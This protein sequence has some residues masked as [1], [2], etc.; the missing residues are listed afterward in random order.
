MASLAT[1]YMIIRGIGGI[2]R[3]TS[4]KNERTWFASQMGSIIRKEEEWPVQLPET[5]SLPPF[6]PYVWHHNINGWSFKWKCWRARNIWRLPCTWFSKNR[7]KVLISF[8]ISCFFFHL[9]V[10]IFRELNAF[11]SRWPRCARVSVAN[12]SAVHFVLLRYSTILF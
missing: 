2:Q 11:R 6:W 5:S 10:I 3:W 7:K 4:Q 8:D 1:I 9:M 12:F